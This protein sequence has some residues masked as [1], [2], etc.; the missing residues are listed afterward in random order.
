MVENFNRGSNDPYDISYGLASA[1]ITATSIAITTTEAAYH[2]MA[3][4]AGGTVFAKVFV[5]DAVSTTAGNLIDVFI[6]G[7]ASSTL[8]ERQIPV[9]AKNGIYV[10]A[11]GVGVEGSLFYGP[12]G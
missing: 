1:A 4:V 11:S 6:V 10:V 12:K 3:I 9:M 8:M 2:G 5:Y 7:S